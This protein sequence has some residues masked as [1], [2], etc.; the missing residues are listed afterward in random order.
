[1]EAKTALQGGTIASEFTPWEQF[2]KAALRD[3][4][5]AGESVG[6]LGQWIDVVELC[7]HDELGHGRRP[8]GT[9]I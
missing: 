1:M 6:Q 3:A 5:D 9:T 8:C 2:V 7:G 4:C